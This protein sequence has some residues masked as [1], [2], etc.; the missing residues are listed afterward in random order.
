MNPLQRIEDRF[1][2]WNYH[3]PRILYALIRSLKPAV[4][5]EIGTYRGYAACYMAQALKEN[6]SGVLYCVDNWSLNSSQNFYPSALDHFWDN[7]KHCEVEDWVKVIEGDSMEVDYPEKVDF[8]YIDGWH[9]YMNVSN[10]F[11]FMAG[12]GAKVICMDDVI[13]TIGPRMFVDALIAHHPKWG[14]SVIDGDGGL[15]I[16]TRMTDRRPIKFAQEIPYPN[17][18][19]SLHLMKR[20]EVAEYYKQ[21]M[22]PE[23]YLEETECL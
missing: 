23:K 18:G 12:L 11:A 9:G 8:A 3:H 15:A 19:T 1:P 14:V 22:V 5:V 7:V 4:C 16:A 10:D 2:D 17:L 21:N 20:E 6:G 13:G